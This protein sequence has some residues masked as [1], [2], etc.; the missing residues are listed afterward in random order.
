MKE[1][2]A[3]KIDRE[4][5][6]EDALW[7]KAE[8]ITLEYTWDEYMPI[9]YVTQAAMVHSDAGITV[10]MTTTE[11]PLRVTEMENEKRICADS[12]M[13]FFFTPNESEQKY[14]NV[15]INPAGACL[16]HVGEKKATPS[17]R[18]VVPTEGSGMHIRTQISPM[19]GWTV[20]FFIPYTLIDA[21][22]D[23]REKVFKA[24]FYKCGDLTVKPHYAAWN[25]VLTD[26]PSYHQPQFF[27][28]VVLSDESL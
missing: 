15:E 24:N 8:K 11:W 4:M 25:P 14:M 23:K 27:G 3:K 1:Y 10:R 22:Y 7:E 20:M 17:V 26:Q 19:E 12:C 2:I 6:V 13:E 28:R 18:G 16:F 21:F 9:P 5:T